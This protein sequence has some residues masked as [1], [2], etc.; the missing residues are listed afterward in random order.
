MPRKRGG[1]GGGGGGGG[2][3]TDV[4][5]PKPNDPC[6][7]ESGRKY[8]KCCKLGGDRIS[9][10]RAA[11]VRRDEEEEEE[12]GDDLQLKMAELLYK[13][14]KFRETESII[15]AVLESPGCTTGLRAR[16]LVLRGRVMYRQ[17]NSGHPNA[18]GRLREAVGVLEE[19]ERLLPADDFK[20]H[21]ELLN[22]RGMVH[23]LLHEPAAARATLE[24]A[25][26]LCH[27]HGVVEYMYEPMIRSNLN[28]ALAQAGFVD[29]AMDHLRKAICLGGPDEPSSGPRHAKLAGLHYGRGE[30]VP[31]LEHYEKAVALPGSQPVMRCQWCR[32]LCLIYAQR[33]YAAETP[34]AWSQEHFEKAMQQLESGIKLAASV[35]GLPPEFAKDFQAA[36]CGTLAKMLLDMLLHTANSANGMLMATKTAAADRRLGNTQYK[37]IRGNVDRIL[38]QAGGSAP[39]IQCLCDSM[40]VRLC[41][42]ESDFEAAVKHGDSFFSAV[43]RGTKIEEHDKN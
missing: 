36:A 22:S 25:L 17:A 42:V 40:M 10:A 18:R 3:G 15:Q 31:A 43:N 30:I 11:R 12:S 24:R 5:K 14:S 39:A 2:G 4:R 1:S 33:V 13:Q 34:D 20:G 6:P 23:N 35:T 29:E 27:S 8:K 7:C 16:C 19:A 26:G 41:V 38:K 21:A 28:D 32:I 37:Q 9:A